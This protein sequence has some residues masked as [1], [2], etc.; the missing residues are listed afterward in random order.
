MCVI[1]I[2]KKGIK[3]QSEK[4]VKMMCEAN[5]H[6]FSMVIHVDGHRPTVYKTLNM[7][8]FLAH[9]RDVVKHY[10][11][12]KTSLYIHARI[13]THGTQRIEN[14]HGWRS[15]GLVFAHNGILSIANRDDLTD[16]ETYFRDIFI[17]AY[18]CGGWRMAEK[19]IAAIIGTSKFAI[20]D[21]DGEIHHYGQYHEEDGILYSNLHFK[22]Y[23]DDDRYAWWNCGKRNRAR[24]T[25]PTN[26]YYPRTESTAQEWNYDF[27]GEDEYPF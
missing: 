2:K 20:M 8:D 15:D 1:S 11:Y 12:R 16:S 21:K 25:N 6:G 5:S 19:T 4:I 9:Y 18:R 23:D 3:F 7:H 14:C 24:Y 22:L 27:L 10:D 13:K 26:A 17:P